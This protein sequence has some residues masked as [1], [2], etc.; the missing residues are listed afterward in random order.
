LAFGLASG[1]AFALAFGLA[2]ALAFGSGLIFCLGTHSFVILFLTVP[3]GHL[4][5]LTY[6]TLSLIFPESAFDFTFRGDDDNFLDFKEDILEDSSVSVA[7]VAGVI[8]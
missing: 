6:L 3:L 5:D 8:S 7:S 4:F 1:L 2:F